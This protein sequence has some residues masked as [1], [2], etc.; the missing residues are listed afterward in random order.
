MEFDASN[1]LDRKSPYLPQHI[2]ERKLNWHAHTGYFDEIATPAKH[3][4]LTRIN[5][6]LRDDVELKS[7]ELTLVLFHSLMGW[8]EPYVDGQPPLPSEIVSLGLKN[9]ETLHQID[10]TVLRSLLAAGMAKRIGL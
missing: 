7:R 10:K 2:F 5:A 3:R 6:D 9:F 8:G 1:I 4:V